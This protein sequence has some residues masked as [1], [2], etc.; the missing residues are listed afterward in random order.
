MTQ[1]NKFFLATILFLSSFNF[2]FAQALIKKGTAVFAKPLEYKDPTADTKPIA[3][4]K[5]N[6]TDETW[7]VYADRDGIQGFKTP[8]SGEVVSTYKFMDKFYVIDQEGDKLHVIPYD[9]AKVLKKSL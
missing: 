2:I 8:T 4:C 6:P 1:M 7:V 9:G 5:K 3:D